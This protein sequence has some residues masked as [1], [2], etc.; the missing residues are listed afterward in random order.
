MDADPVLF[1]VGAD[2]DWELDSLC[3]EEMDLVEN[4]CTTIESTHASIIYVDPDR[5]E[6]VCAKFSLNE[7][8][9]RIVDELCIRQ[10]CDVIV[11]GEGGTGKTQVILCAEEI[12]GDDAC[13]VV[14]CTGCAASTAGGITL[15]AFFGVS[16]LESLR[17]WSYDDVLP[18]IRDRLIGIRLFVVEEFSMVP[19]D[20]LDAIPIILRTN[21]FLGRIVM[22][23]HLLQ[24]PPVRSDPFYCSTYYKQLHSQLHDVELTDDVHPYRPIPNVYYLTT[25]CRQRGDNAYASLLSR[26]SRDWVG[27]VGMRQADIDTI[28]QQVRDISE[29]SSDATVVYFY[30]RDVN[31]YNNDRYAE[32]DAREF[33]Y[34]ANVFT[35]AQP[36]EA[37][38]DRAIRT[39][40][41]P[42]KGGVAAR[43]IDASGV[44][45]DVRLKEGCVVRLTRN[46]SVRDNLVNGAIGTIVSIESSADIPVINVLFVGTERPVSIIPLR[47]VVYSA[48]TAADLQ[49]YIRGDHVPPDL[50]GL[51]ESGFCRY[52]V[53]VEQIP[54]TYSWAMTIHSCQSLTLNRL[55]LSVPD[56]F[57]ITSF[58]NALVYVA[59]SRT[60]SLEHV[61]L[62]RKIIPA[63]VQVDANAL[64]ADEV[65]RVLS[66]LKSSAEPVD[67]E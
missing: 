14:A 10:T 67:P 46:I 59:L 8:Q 24:L 13:I 40:I 5:V 52:T 30:K 26:V 61:Y 31:A 50:N 42:G 65:L 48:K 53:C 60:S 45:P 33:V 27:T 49:E 51:P 1:D 4:A 25:P 55:V 41:C 63:H 7:D 47:T 9:R 23:G 62:L 34:H 22:S 64:R 19:A 15:C 20:I 58:L 35:M 37:G 32:L 18:K 36:M 66:S 43:I 38:R 3:D 39:D 56:S 54:L 17:K 21:G 6:E 11:S 28:N 12:F 44:P 2:M 57:K 16:S 29:I